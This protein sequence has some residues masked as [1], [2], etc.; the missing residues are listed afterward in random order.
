MTNS[1]SFYSAESLSL[2][3][4]LTAAVVALWK[5]LGTKDQQCDRLIS[6]TMLQSAAMQSLARSLDRLRTEGC[7][8]SSDE[9]SP[10]AIRE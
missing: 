4:A 5:A 2:I 6:E 10:P 3:A 1:A 9:S 8:R 7:K